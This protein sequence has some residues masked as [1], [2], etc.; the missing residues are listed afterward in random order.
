M[1]TRRDVLVGSMLI[2]GAAIAQPSGK[3]GDTA[4]RGDALLGKHVIQPL[5]FDPKKLSGLSEKLLSAT[6]SV[7]AVAGQSSIGTSTPTAHA[8]IGPATTSTRWRSARRCW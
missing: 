4:T 6:R 5:P 3:R 8:S 7:A 2:G 1:M